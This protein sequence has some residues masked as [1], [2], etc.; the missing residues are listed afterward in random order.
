LTSGALLRIPSIETA[1]RAQD[2]IVGVVNLQR[3]DREVIR[4]ENP[5]P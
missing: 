5:P 1:D 2:V 3:L 4:V